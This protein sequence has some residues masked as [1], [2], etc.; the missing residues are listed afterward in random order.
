[1]MK[2]SRLMGVAAVLWALAGCATSRDD[3][4]M[5]AADVNWGPGTSAPQSYMAD[6]G[7]R[8]GH[9][10]PYTFPDGSS[11]EGS[12]GGGRRR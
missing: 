12:G 6:N 3:S 9:Y 4:S 5:R 7:D 10:P 1:M 2:V 11:G 8:V